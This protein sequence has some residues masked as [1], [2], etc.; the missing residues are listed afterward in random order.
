MQ[1]VE[2]I[3][4]FLKFSGRSVNGAELLHQRHARL[5]QHVGYGLM[6]WVQG[7]KILVAFS[8]QFVFLIEEIGVAQ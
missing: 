8:G 6:P 1:S 7:F 5:I 4:G 3:V 2:V